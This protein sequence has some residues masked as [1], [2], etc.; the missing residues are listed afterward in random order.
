MNTRPGGPASFTVPVRR[1]YYVPVTDRLPAN[2]P[3]VHLQ[4]TP[5]DTYAS[6]CSTHHREFPFLISVNVKIIRCTH[7]HGDSRLMHTSTRF[8]K[9]LHTS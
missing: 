6:M 9:T 5:P 4:N 2:H 3:P 1:S 7:T 8:M